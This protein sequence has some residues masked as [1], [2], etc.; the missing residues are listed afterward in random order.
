MKTL[1]IFKKKYKDRLISE[2][3]EP[4]RLTHHEDY[5]NDKKVRLLLSDDGNDYPQDSKGE[6]YPVCGNSQQKYGSKLT[7]FLNVLFY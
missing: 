6:T 3:E 2:T 4:D 5:K 7:K 1:Q